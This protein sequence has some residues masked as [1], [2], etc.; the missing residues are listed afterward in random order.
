[1]VP[2]ATT[3]YLIIYS[4]AKPNNLILPYSIFL[5]AATIFAVIAIWSLWQNGIPAA[6]GGF[7]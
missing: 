1:M 5:A 7:L 2:V 3:R 6:D 4:F